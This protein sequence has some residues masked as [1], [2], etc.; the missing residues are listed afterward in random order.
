M[1]LKV[2]RQ[3]HLRQGENEP[4]GR[5]EVIPLGPVSIIPQEHVVII[6]VA[7]AE[8]DEGNPPTITAAVAGAMGLLSPHVANRINAERGVE[9]KKGA[10]HASQDKTT[11]AAHPTAV[12]KA[13]D[14]G[15]GEA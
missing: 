7:L 5:I 11:K 3:P 15:Q 1:A 8:R 14:K 9:H 2:I 6:V 10:P 13:H 4:F 12:E